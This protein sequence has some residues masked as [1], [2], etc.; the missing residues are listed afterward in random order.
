[1]QKGQTGMSVLLIAQRFD[2]ILARGAQGRV[3]GA[4]GAAHNPHQKGYSDP[5]RLNLDYQRRHAHH[6]EPRDEGKSH[7]HRNAQ[8]AHQNRFLGVTVGVAF[9]F[10]ARLGVMKVKATPTVTPSKLTRIAS[11]ALRWVWL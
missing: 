3:E 5:T 6:T 4:Y 1:M 10:I 9:T 11:W 2:G 8:Q 7:T